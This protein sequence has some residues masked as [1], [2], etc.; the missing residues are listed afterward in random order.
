MVVIFL[1]AIFNALQDFSTAK[2]MNS[3][4]GLLPA[5]A[6]VIRDGEKKTIAASDIVAGDLIV[7]SQGIRVPADIR[8]V[9]AS[10]DLTFDRAVLT[11]E[12]EEVPAMLDDTESN[13]LESKSIA[14]LGS[15]VAS[16]SGVGVVIL[17]GPK[18]VMG[19]INKLTN[20]GKEKTTNL[21]REINR[22]VIIIVCLTVTL[23]LIMLI[24]WLGYL[25]PHHPAFLNV[26]GL[27]TNLMSL[28]VAC[29]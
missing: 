2:V 22:F 17:T 20:T 16:G 1:Q 26:V 11:G 29:E 18:T 3:I 15:F 10:D 12:S 28:V 27:L 14:F 19:R 25:R 8:L 6:V 24:F 7:L 5:N 9:S 23:V 21:Q 13:F 4:K